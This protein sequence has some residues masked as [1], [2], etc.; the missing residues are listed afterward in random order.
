MKNRHFA[1]KAFVVAVSFLMLVLLFAP[2]ALA[3]PKNILY[4]IGDGMGPQ[5][6][7]AARTYNGG[8]LSFETMAYSGEVIGFSSHW[9]AL[10]QTVGDVANSNDVVRPARRLPRV[11]ERNV[12]VPE[13]PPHGRP[14]VVVLF[15]ES[16][17]YDSFSTAFKAK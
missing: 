10:V 6:V 4:F 14:N 13:Q 1:P 8:P 5:Q 3:G 2:A 11:G 9:Y 17:S 15:L 12:P 16:V 7:K